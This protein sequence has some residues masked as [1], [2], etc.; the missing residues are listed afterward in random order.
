MVYH[1]LI[2]QLLTYISFFVCKVNFLKN[3]FLNFFVQSDN[4][5]IIIAVFSLFTFNAVVEMVG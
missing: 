4:F 1:F 3:N 5:C 2:L